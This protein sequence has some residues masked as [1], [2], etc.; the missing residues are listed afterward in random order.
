MVQWSVVKPCSRVRCFAFPVHARIFVLGCTRVTGVIETPGHKVGRLLLVDSLSKSSTTPIAY[1]VC[2]LKVNLGSRSMHTPTPQPP[3]SS[4]WNNSP[5]TEY[6]Y[7]NS[8]TCSN[9]QV[10]LCSFEQVCTTQ[11]DE[12]SEWVLHRAKNGRKSCWKS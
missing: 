9:E 4:N 2:G 12:D 3:N 10:N 6:T 1:D 11:K 8:L 5:P 7:N